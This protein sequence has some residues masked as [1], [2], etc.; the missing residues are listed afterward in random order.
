MPP[1]LTERRLDSQRPLC[2]R[3][4]SSGGRSEQLFLHGIRPRAR[5]STATALR[6]PVRC[7]ACFARPSM[8]LRRRT[9]CGA[10][11]APTPA[12]PWPSRTTMTMASIQATMTTG[13]RT[14]PALRSPRPHRRQMSRER[15]RGSV[16]G[17]RRRRQATRR[18]RGG[19]SLRG[20]SRRRRTTRSSSSKTSSHRSGGAR[21]GGAAGGG[22][23]GGWWWGVLSDIGQ[24]PRRK[25]GGSTEKSEAEKKFGSSRLFVC[26]NFVLASRIMTVPPHTTGR[27][28]KRTRLEAPPVH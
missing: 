7:S 6:A 14:G 21:G 20:G 4:T 24:R 19:A 26:H 17:L 2:L 22:G 27:S 13:M 12:S 16:L 18:L 10:S 28:F 15:F 8:R 11:R 9:S 23:G 1:S 25:S 5:I 3:R